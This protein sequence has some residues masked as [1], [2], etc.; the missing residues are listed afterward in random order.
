MRVTFLTVIL[1]MAAMFLPGEAGATGEFP[2]VLHGNS[3]DIRWTQD[4]FFVHSG[5]PLLQLQLAPGLVV[6]MGKGTLMRF[7]A[8][9]IDAA[10]YVL[11]ID[12][13]F[14]LVTIP[15]TDRVYTLREGYYPVTLAP[16]AAQTFDARDV[17]M[18]TL[19]DPGIQQGF[20][21]GDMVLTQQDLYIASLR[22]NISMINTALVSVI[23]GIFGH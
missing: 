14:V 11:T 20:L 23:R 18:P 22:I 21:L 13:G 5:Q 9:D 2:K 19:A 10:S 12:N 1:A 6:S 7:S 3:Q 4:A 17:T 15:G 16:G 8:L